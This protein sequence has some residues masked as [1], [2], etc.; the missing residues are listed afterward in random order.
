MALGPSHEEELGNTFPK[1][2]TQ[3]KI[4]VSESET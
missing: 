4:C 2:E 3:C 1:K